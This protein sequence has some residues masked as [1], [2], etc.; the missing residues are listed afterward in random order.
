VIGT[1]NAS[2]LSIQ[3]FDWYIP[4]ADE[5]D[6]LVRFD[7]SGF[8]DKHNGIATVILSNPFM[9]DR[10]NFTLVAL[11]DLT[12]GGGMVIPSIQ[13]DYGKHWRFK[14]EADIAFG[15]DQTEIGASLPADTSSV[16]GALKDDDQLLFRITYQF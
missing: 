6:K 13:Y 15:G 12:E 8:F 16:F 4:D 14:V 2:M 9:Y 7:G 11:M 1:S 5:S 10:L 3:V